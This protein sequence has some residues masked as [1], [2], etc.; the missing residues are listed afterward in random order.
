MRQGVLPVT[1]K[2]NDKNSEW[3]GETSPSAEKTQIPKVTANAKFYKGVMDRL[4]KRIQ[5]VCP[6][7]I[8]SRDSFLVAR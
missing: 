6:V 7:A 1:L 2:Q 5:Q 4:L 8:C 3:V